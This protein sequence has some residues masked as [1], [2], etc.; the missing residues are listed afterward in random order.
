MSKYGLQ[1]LDTSSVM[2]AHTLRYTAHRHVRIF[3]SKIKSNLVTEDSCNILDFEDSRLTRY[4]YRI[5]NLVLEVSFDE[6]S[7]D[8]L[9][10]GCSLGSQRSHH[11][12][13]N[14][15]NKKTYKYTEKISRRDG[16][17]GI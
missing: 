1:I 14:N 2:D 15:N 13:T 3:C 4:V 17:P 7:G 6:D 9:S 12:N 8:D 5:D 10:F 11:L 16:T